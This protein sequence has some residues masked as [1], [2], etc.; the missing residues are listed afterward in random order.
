MAT[1]PKTKP[2]SLLR[3]SAKG[4]IHHLEITPAKNSRG[5]QGFITRIHRHPPVGQ[6]PGPLGYVP[7]PPPEDVPHEDGKDMLAHAGRAF[8]I[9]PDDGDGPDMEDEKDAEGD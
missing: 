3:N 5:G 4:T 8:G 7:P 9:K 6:K 1:R 2:L